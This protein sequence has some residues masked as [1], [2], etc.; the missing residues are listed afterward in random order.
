MA[1]DL[2][3]SIKQQFFATTIQIGSAKVVIGQDG[4][5]TWEHLNQAEQLSRQ[6]QSELDILIRELRPI[7]HS[8]GGLVAG[9]EDFYRNWAQQNLVELDIPE[10]EPEMKQSLFWVTQEA[11][12]NISCYS[13][14]NNFIVKLY[15]IGLGIFIVIQDNG[16]GFDLTSVT[17]KG[18]GL[19][20][21]LHLTDRTQAAVYAWREGIVRRDP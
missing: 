18:M 5:K 3:D 2:H 12:P 14:A 13:G 16:S 17:E 21:R 6:A 8:S 7:T 1:R 11:L 10:I 15:S 19:I 20:S 4:E 9:V